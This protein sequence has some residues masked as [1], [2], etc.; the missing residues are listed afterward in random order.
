[1]IIGAYT[2]T[3]AK[4][5][6]LAKGQPLF[7]SP[8]GHRVTQMSRA[9]TPTYIGRAGTGWEAV[10]IGTGVPYKDGQVRPTVL[11]VPAAAGTVVPR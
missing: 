4:V 3:S 5:K 2:V 9:A 6:H 10:V 8:G 7:D 11:Y 1:M